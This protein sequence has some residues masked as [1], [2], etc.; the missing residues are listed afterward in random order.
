METEKLWQK[1]INSNRWDLVWILL[2]S[3]QRRSLP[4]GLFP[5]SKFAHSRSFSKTHWGNQAGKQPCERDNGLFCGRVEF[6]VSK[7]GY[8]L[9]GFSME[10]I[11]IRLTNH[12]TS[13]PVSQ[14]SHFHY[15]LIIDFGQDKRIESTDWIF[16]QIVCLTA[17]VSLQPM[18][19]SRSGIEV[20]GSDFSFIFSFRSFKCFDRIASR[21]L[22]TGAKIGVWCA[23]WN[24]TGLAMETKSHRMEVS[25]YRFG[26]Q[27]IHKVVVPIRCVWRR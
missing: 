23:S 25:Q 18:R 12:W 16:F 11:F 1:P 8:L 26:C 3:Q 17:M 10:T 15:L 14:S 6:T 9:G 19:P 20:F 22:Q 24:Y 21:K 5:H 7:K 4:D 2:V 27:T 13:Q